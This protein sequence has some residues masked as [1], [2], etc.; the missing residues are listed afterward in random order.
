MCVFVQ[1]GVTPERY[2]EWMKPVA[3]R[4]KTLLSGMDSVRVAYEK[5]LRG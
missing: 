4:T 5:T 1:A 2:E 3:H